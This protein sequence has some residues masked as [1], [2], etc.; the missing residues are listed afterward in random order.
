MF[1]KLILVAAAVGAGYGLLEFRQNPADIAEPVYAEIRL[2]LPIPTREISAVAYGKMTSRTDCE[3]RSE[4]ALEKSMS[5]CAE[6]RFS[7][8][9]CRTD[10]EPRYLRLFDDEP[11]HATYIAFHRGSRF[12]RDVRLVYW[13]LTPQES[14]EVCALVQKAAKRNYSGRVECVLGTLR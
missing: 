11:I 3:R 13:G 14:Q 1:G 10:L 6:C 4:R 7:L 8:S 5:D 2:S 12:E 9:S